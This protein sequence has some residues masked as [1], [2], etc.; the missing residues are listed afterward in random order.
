M[1][2]KVGIRLRKVKG[3]LISKRQT[4][5]IAVRERADVLRNKEKKITNLNDEDDTEEINERQTKAA[6]EAALE[7]GGTTTENSVSKLARKT[8][9]HEEGQRHENQDKRG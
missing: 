9:T 6:V 4:N 8:K 2:R 7:V 1:R 3:K 5:A